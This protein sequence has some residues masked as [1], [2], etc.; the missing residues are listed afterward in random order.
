[1]FGRLHFAFQQAKDALA[2][3]GSAATAADAVAS[4]KKMIIL[5]FA[6]A[7]IKSRE[8]GSEVLT[9]AL[10]Q[11]RRTN[12]AV[13]SA[14]ED[15]SRNAGGNMWTFLYSVLGRLGWIFVQ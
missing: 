10:H 1:M 3:G 15:G 11:S 4:I 2:T 9:V 5:T 8:S 12:D 14:C 7:T 6:R 13:D